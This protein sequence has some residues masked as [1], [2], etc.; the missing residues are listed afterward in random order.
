MEYAEVFSLQTDTLA[1]SLHVPLPLDTNLF[2]A[3]SMAFSPPSLGLEG[4]TC[5][6]SLFYI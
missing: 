3:S 5:N 6:F 2:L 1:L 4:V